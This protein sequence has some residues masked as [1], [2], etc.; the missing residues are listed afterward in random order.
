M[1]GSVGTRGTGGRGLPAAA[2]GRASAMLGGGSV[3]R[4][5]DVDVGQARERRRQRRLT[6][7]AV[8]LWVTT[9]AVWWRVL[10]G[11]SLNPLDG[12][13]LGPTPCCGSR[14]C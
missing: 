4:A 2:P 11:G 6:R 5:A 1:P 14:R 9:L 7:L 3:L 13:R 12:L 8:V 10:T